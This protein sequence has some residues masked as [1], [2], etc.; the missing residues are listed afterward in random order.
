MKKR[1]CALCSRTKARR[2]CDRHNHEFICSQCCAESRDSACEGCQYFA[3]ARQYHLSKAPKTKKKQF[4]VEINEE[5]EKAVDDAL[6]L[7]EGGNIRNGERI[8]EELKI[9]HPRNHMVDYGIGVVNAFKQ[10]YDQAIECFTRATDA[11]P[12][13]IEAHFNKAVAYKK[14]LDIRNAIKSFKEVIAIGDPQADM[15]RQATGFVSGLEREIMETHSITL[16]QYFEAQ[17]EFEK[18]FSCMEKEAWQQAIPGFQKCIKLNK[19]HPQSYGNL[20]LCYA[21]LGRKAEAVAAFEKALEIDPNYEPAMVNKAVVESLQDGEKLDQESFKS[22]DY[23]RDYPLKKRSFV[24][25]IL[26]E[27]LGQ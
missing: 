26:D 14:K 22:I 3:E 9:R 17:D 18:A 27:L 1:K 8:L 24:R 4:I 16:D 23:Y 10:E 20:G 11:F 21:R 13:F 25:S 5:V 7:V 2:K 19:K 15:V 6:A 12:Y